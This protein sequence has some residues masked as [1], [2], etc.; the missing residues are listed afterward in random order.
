MDIV[1]GFNRI[2][3]G[4]KREISGSPLKLAPRRHRRAI[5]KLSEFARSSLEAAYL[6]EALHIAQY[7]NQTWGAVGGNFETYQNRLSSVLGTDNLDSIANQAR[8]K[9]GQLVLLDIGSDSNPIPPEKRKQDDIVITIAA[10]EWR[11]KEEIAESEKNGFY[12]IEGSA[13][14]PE[15]WEKIHGLLARLFEEK[16]IPAAKFNM[17]ISNMNAGWHAM[18]LAPS[19]FSRSRNVRDRYFPPYLRYIGSLIRGEALPGTTIIMDIPRWAW[20]EFIEGIAGKNAQITRPQN[21]DA[22]RITLE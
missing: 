15:T 22:V 9:H 4:N 17:I 7:G 6:Y 21:V 2:F 18:P 12:L 14:L 13:G 8:E 20:P 10:K 16:K 19:I 11:E 3:H 5:R 1:E